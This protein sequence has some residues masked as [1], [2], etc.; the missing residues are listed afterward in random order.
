MVNE[1]DV[2]VISQLLMSTT[3]REVDRFGCSSLLMVW[4]TEK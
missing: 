1:F 3:P 4:T 2:T